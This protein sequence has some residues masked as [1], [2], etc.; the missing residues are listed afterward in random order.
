MSYLFSQIHYIRS[1]H[2][3]G[4]NFNLWLLLVLH[5]LSDTLEVG[6][7]MG[8]AAGAL[9]SDRPQTF[10]QKI[11]H[12]LLVNDKIKL[13]VATMVRHEHIHHYCAGSGPD[14]EQ[15]SAATRHT[16]QTLHQGANGTV[17]IIYIM[18][19]TAKP[20]YCLRLPSFERRQTSWN[21]T[22]DFIMKCY[23]DRDK[24]CWTTW[25][26]RR[27]IGHHNQ[28]DFLTSVIQGQRRVTYRF[29]RGQWG[30]HELREDS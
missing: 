10:F 30:I 19:V 21:L 7:N 20:I 23:E 13:Q 17:W 18:S 27:T 22:Q 1:L 15:C 24:K 9:L 4:L 11:K 5:D 28:L 26:Y 3:H 14:T 16:Y 8:K 6:I 25:R 12:P 2:F 29:T